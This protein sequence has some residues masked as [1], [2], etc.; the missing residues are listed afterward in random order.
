VDVPVDRVRSQITAVLAAWGMPGDLAETTAEVM[1][2]TDVTGVDSHGVSMLMFYERL[3]RSGGLDLGARPTVV[4]ENAVTAL[5][6][7]HNGLG[8]PAGDFAMRLAISK[9][10]SNAVGA[11]SVFHSNH[12]GAAGYYAALAAEQGVVGLVTTSAN[13]KCVAATRAAVPTLGTNPVAF[14]A[15]T[16]RNPHFLLDMATS[17][18]AA[19][20]V[21]VH[22]LNDR[23]LPPGWVLDEF[24]KPIQDAERAWR[25]L[26]KD[27]G[28]NNDGND[29]GG[30][31]PLGGT[32]DMASYKGYGLAM[33]VQI[34][35]ATLSGAGFSATSPSGPGTSDDTGH[36][37]L[38]IDPRSFRPAGEFEEDLDAAI[39]ALHDTPPI[40]PAEPVL[41]AG[42]P[43]AQARQKRSRDG[44][45]IPPTLME[46]LRGVSERAGTEFVLDHG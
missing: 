35:S 28:D 19:N 9:A 14:A 30:L 21:K 27:D 38:A 29:V 12:F 43:Q 39:D 3:V 32:P 10:R 31:T 15:P 24:G 17:T 8:H 20:K 13:G 37:F 46:Q 26:D 2:D 22:Y 4:R 7:A 18:V 36:F 45:P 40:D 44:I 5:V 41:V 1:V 6:D 33:M 34:L 42:D 16:H 11:V 25:G 23:P